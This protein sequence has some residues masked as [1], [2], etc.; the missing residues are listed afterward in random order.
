MCIYK[1]TKP[2]K[3]RS[4]KFDLRCRSS[5][6]VK[7]KPHS[8]STSLC[9]LST[10]FGSVCILLLHFEVVLVTY[11][12]KICLQFLSWVIGTCMIRSPMYHCPLH[13]WQK[14]WLMK[15]SSSGM[16]H[17]WQ[18]SRRKPL[19]Q[20]HHHQPRWVQAPLRAPIL[21]WRNQGS[22]TEMHR[23]WQIGCLMFNSS[24]RWQGWRRQL[25]LSRW[26]SPYSRGNP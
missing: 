25:R 19:Q 1:G 7:L 26:L 11:T 24:A 10:G 18:H 8:S 15:S 23:S 5:D 2:P 12:R 14:T 4:W 6:W 22:T 3:I 16:L 13:K 21:N 20:Q 9:K 17:T